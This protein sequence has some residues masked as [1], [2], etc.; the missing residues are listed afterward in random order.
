MLEERASLVRNARLEVRLVL[1]DLEL[2]SFEKGDD[3]VE[4]SAIPDDL[5]ISGND[6]RQPEQVIGNPRSDPAAARRVPP[7]LDVALLELPRRRAQQVLPCQ[8]GLGDGERHHVLK[9][10]AKPVRAAGL[11]ERRPRPHATG[12]RLV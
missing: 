2:G 10:I 1:S 11:I 7:V 4:D 9:L 8:L 3:F 5:E 12:Q 6:V